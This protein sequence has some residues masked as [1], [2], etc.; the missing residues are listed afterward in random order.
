MHRRDDRAQLLLA[1]LAQDL[2]RAAHWYARAAA[3]GDLGAQLTYAMFLALGKG[4]ETDF[5]AACHWATLSYHQGNQNAE[6]PLS[7]IRAQASGAAADAAQAFMAARDAGDEAEALAQLER[8]AECGSV[9]AQYALAQLLHAGQG[10][11]RNDVEALFWLLEAAAQG[12]AVEPQLFDA[13]RDAAEAQMAE[14]D[15]AEATSA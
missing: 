1:V 8:A 15:E 10:T 13:V 9:D 3:Q 5:A 2:E 6:K 11:A 14:A 7:I 4:V 12:R